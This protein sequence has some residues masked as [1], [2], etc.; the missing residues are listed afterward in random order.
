MDIGARTHRLDRHPLFIQHLKKNFASDGRVEI[1]A[2][3]GFDRQGQTIQAPSV[4][5]T[6]RP[7]RLVA[8]RL[9]DGA[10]ILNL[11][12]G[13]VLGAVSLEASSDLQQWVTLGEFVAGDFSTYFVD[14]EAVRFSTRFYRVARPDATRRGDDRACSLD[15]PR[16]SL[17][18]SPS[19]RR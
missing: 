15:A 2:A 16:V 3:I 5:I 13:W 8:T 7:V 19:E 14:D 1:G 17:P 10:V 9:P 6:V 11:V 4:R 12:P 18:P